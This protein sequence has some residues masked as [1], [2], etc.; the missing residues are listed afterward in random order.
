MIIVE[1]KID[2]KSVAED[3]LNELINEL[4]IEQLKCLKRA[5]KSGNT[6]ILTRNLELVYGFAKEFKEEYGDWPSLLK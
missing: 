3:W 2:V 4:S 5:L 1:Q 6:D